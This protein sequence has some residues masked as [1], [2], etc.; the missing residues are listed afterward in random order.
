M[1]NFA[2]VMISPAWWISVLIAGV[3]MNFIAAWTKPLLERLLTRSVDKCE[4]RIKKQKVER[5]K[6]IAQ[7]LK[8]SDDR[9]DFRFEVIQTFQKSTNYLIFGVAVMLIAFGTNNFWFNSIS[10]AV[11]IVM[12][13]TGVSSY[14]DAVRSRQVLS[15]VIERKKNTLDTAGDLAA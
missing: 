11:S 14:I 15:D 6:L 10:F 4:I 9:L 5:E 8:N 13:I 1:L 12:L 7:L 2:E 3:L